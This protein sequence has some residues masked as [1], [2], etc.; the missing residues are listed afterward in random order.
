MKRE[1]HQQKYYSIFNPSRLVLIFMIT[2][3][4]GN[5]IETLFCALILGEWGSRQG[6]LY[7]PFS[8][9]YGAG[10]VLMLLTYPLSKRS[11]LLHI[12]VGG[13]LGGSFEVLCSLLQSGVFGSTSWNYAYM[14]VGIPLFGGR[15]SVLFMVLWG[16]ATVLWVRGGYPRLNRLL[17]RLPKR[18]MQVTALIAAV[19]MTANIAVSGLAIKR[20]SERLEEH[21]A[22]SSLAVFLDR[23]YPNARMK[24]VFSNMTFS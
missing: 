10:A 23:H 14:T 2:S 18:A 11:L 5:L 6:V 21:P 19:W 16:I 20:W 3:L 17:G 24:E 13:I 9:I 1:K 12:A 7:G 4:A 8:P 15:T 22:D